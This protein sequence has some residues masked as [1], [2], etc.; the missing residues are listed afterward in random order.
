MMRRETVDLLRGIFWLC[1]LIIGL[2][3]WCFDA[4]AVTADELRA[5]QR[6]GDIAEQVLR[7]GGRECPEGVRLVSLVK[8]E[9]YKLKVV[10]GPHGD[11][12]YTYLIQWW[13]G[14]DYTAVPMVSGE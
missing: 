13:G 7:K 8:G 5:Y 1:V 3:C 6:L 4:K 11:F 9:G 2:C 14:N 10:C 12:R